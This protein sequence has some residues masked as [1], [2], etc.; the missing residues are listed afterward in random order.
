MKPVYLIGVALLMSGCGVETAGTA[1]VAGAGQARQIE[2]AQQLKQ[3]VQ[4]QL[5]AA[6]QAEQQKLK[7]TERAA[8]GY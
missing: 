6:M 7:E 2:Q 5:D 8:A 4:E 3:D 1:A